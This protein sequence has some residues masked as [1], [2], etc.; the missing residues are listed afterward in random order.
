MFKHIISGGL[1]LATIVAGSLVGGATAN[2]EK[3]VDR[4]SYVDQFSDR[5]D[6]LSDICGFEVLFEVDARGHARFFAD[7]SIQAQDRGTFTLINPA[8][9]KTLTQFWAGQFRGQGTETWNDDGT[10]TIVFDEEYNGV[11]E[12]WLDPDGG[13]LI[14]DRGRARISGTVVIDFGDPDDPFDDQFD[15]DESFDLRGPHPIL[16]GGGLDPTLACE[17][18]A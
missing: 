12:K 17:L 15:V 9:G 18:L 5:D 8:N 4:D 10:L 1:A 6:F 13:V 3:A 14:M 11:H 7:G 16:E 2:A